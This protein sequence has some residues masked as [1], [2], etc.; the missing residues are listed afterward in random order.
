MAPTLLYTICVLGAVALYLLLRPSR[1]PVAVIGA[2]LGL[3]AFAW[4]LVTSIEYF[5]PSHRPGFYYTIFSVIAL[6]AGVRMI[7][8][9]KPVYCA[10]YFVM[11]VLSSAGL[12]LLLAAEFLAFALIIVYAGAI[13]VTYMFVLMLAQQSETPDGPSGQPAYDRVP[14]E[15]AFAAVV[16]FLMLALLT[17]ASFQGVEQLPESISAQSASH[18]A[19]RELDKLPGRLQQIVDELE[20]GAKPVLDEHGEAVVVLAGDDMV[21]VRIVG[22]GETGSRLIELPLD[23]APTN[24]QRVGLALVARFPVS[25]ELAGIILLLAMFGAAVLSRRQIELSEDELREA[26]GLRRLSGQ[27][28]HHEEESR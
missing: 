24:I 22:E 21:Y 2:V 19:M 1:Q 9:T 10:L 27:H 14:R 23:Q 12:F 3:A 16:G 15:P 13:L 7:T 28:D 11:V 5:A 25:L 18:E 8:H 26:A 17:S 4:L 6:A 20:P